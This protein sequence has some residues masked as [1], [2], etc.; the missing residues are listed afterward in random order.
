MDS[1]KLTPDQGVR[2]ADTVGPMLGYV[3]RLACRMQQMGWRS[4]DPMYV[5][6]WDSY[7]ALHA[8]HV[9]ARY[10]S[11]KPGTAGKPTDN[12]APGDCI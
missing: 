3:Y 6:A 7:H 2:L 8:L 10:A 12:S 11:C 1:S 4:D 5:A 9:H